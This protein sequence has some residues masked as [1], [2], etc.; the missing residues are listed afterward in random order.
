VIA[1]GRSTAADVG[2][3][4]RERL[5]QAM[6]GL[7]CSVDVELLDSHRYPG[8][9]ETDFAR[10]EDLCGNLIVRQARVANDALLVGQTIR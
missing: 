1:A 6:S 8:R 2:D 7:R 10:R 5:Q 4:R 9:I 3:L